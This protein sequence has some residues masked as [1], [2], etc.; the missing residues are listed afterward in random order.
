MGGHGVRGDRTSQLGTEAQGLL[1][2]RAWVAQPPVT[3][4]CAS[5]NLPLPEAAAHL[6]EEQSPL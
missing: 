5:A 1:V 2:P 3:G 4:L 6:Q